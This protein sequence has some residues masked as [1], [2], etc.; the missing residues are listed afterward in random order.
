VRVG[1]LLDC[2][3]VLEPRS[4]SWAEPFASSGGLAWTRPPLNCSPAAELEDLS[5]ATATPNLSR[6]LQQL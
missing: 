3:E 5:E 1:R 2:V 6:H 4:A